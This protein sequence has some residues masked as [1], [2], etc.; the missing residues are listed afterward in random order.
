VNLGFG[1]GLRDVHFSYLLE[2]PPAAWGVDWFE[3]VSENFFD[4]DGFAG[5]VLD[6]VREERAVVMHGVALSIGGTDPLD[7]DYLNKLKVLAERLDPALISDHLCWTG[8]DGRT[9]HDLLPLPLTE[10]CLDHVAARVHT[11]QDFLGRQIVLENPSTYV[12]FEVS[13]MPEWEFLGRLA[14]TTDCALLL[15]VNNV[16][17]SAYNHGLDPVAYIEGIPP[18]RVAYVH[19]AGPSDH[20]TFL[21]DSHDHPVVDDVWPLYDLAQERT[22]GVATLLEWDADIPAFPDLV[23]ELDRARVRCLS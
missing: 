23:S 13:A 9:T 6:R 7:C 3:I 21:L 8:V 17:V 10:E 12:E 5:H 22:G 14:E 16:Y 15:D 11:V 19:L 2:Q 1:V 18:E 4:D 20:G